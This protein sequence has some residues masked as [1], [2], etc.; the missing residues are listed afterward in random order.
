VNRYRVIGP[1]AVRGNPPGT[2]FSY[3]FTPGQEAALLGVHIAPEPMPPPP[4]AKR[5]KPRKRKT[6]GPRKRALS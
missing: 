2:S 4:P 3:P 1:R 5:R 6:T